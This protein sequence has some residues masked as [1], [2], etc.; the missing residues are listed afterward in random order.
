MV[1]K[2]DYK[3]T[4]LMPQTNFPMKGNLNKKEI[5]IEKHW[6]EIRL[7]EKMLSKNKNNQHFILHDGPPYAN[8][9][10]HIGHALNKIL[11]DFIL[12]FKNMQ[13][14]YAPY[15]PGWDTHGLPIEIA[16]LK[17]FS[18]E[19]LSSKNL[20]IT[21][22]RKF[23]LCFIEK[24][25][26]NFKRLGI[27]GHWD[28]YYSTLD[29]SYI[30]DQIRIFGQM[31]T[32]KLIFKNLKPVYW[33]PFLQSSLAES[34]IEYRNYKSLSIFI[35]FDII[36]S[37][38]FPN[39]QLLVWTT[40]PWTLPS[41]E[42]ICAHPNQKYHL[43][44]V[45]GKQYIIGAATLNS[46]RPKL[47]WEKMEIIN[48]FSGKKLENL[49]YIN[50]LFSK[51]RRVVLD[52]FVS[53][54]EGT[55]LVS[56][57]PGHGHDDFIIGQKYN[58]DI[59]CSIDKKGLMTEIAGIYKGI[60]FTE[61]NNLIVESLRTKNLL[62]K[63]ESITH[64][65]PHDN[66][67]QKPVIFLA[68]PQWFLNVSKI[69]DKLLK[70]VQKIKWHPEWG[71]KKMHNMMSEREHWNISRQRKWGVPIPIIYTENHEPITDINI[72][73]HIADL[74]EKN[75]KEIWHKWDAI[76]LLPPNYQN[77]KSPNQIFYKEQDIIDVWFDSGTSYSIIQRISDNFFPVNL[78][79]EGADQY[80]GWFN[81]SLITS[82]AVFNQSPYQQVITHGFVLD[83][84]G[85]KMSKSLN[86][87]V[88]PLK[89]INQTGADVL[90]LWVS[91]IDY[92]ND[93]KIDSS[94]LEQIQEKYRKI[95]NTIRFMLGNLNDFNPNQNYV[96]FNN[97]DP[98]HQTII[99]EFKY[100]LIKIIDSY[101]N[102]DFEQI[103]SLL[104]P[105][106]TTKIS[107][108]YLDFAKDI[109]Y[110]ED[111]NNLERRMI[112]SNIYDLLLDFLKILT[113]I[114]PHTTS[115][116]YNSL[117]FKNEEDIYLEK[118]PQIK[119][120]KNFINDTYSENVVIIQ[121]AYKLFLNLREIVLKKLEESRQ[122]KLIRKSL[123][124]KLILHLTPEYIKALEILKI[125]KKLNQILIVSQI[126]I[127]EK[128]TLN[129]TILMANGITCPRC[130][131][132][133]STIKKQG[134]LCQRCFSVLS[135]QIL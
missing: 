111:Q 58:L 15:I 31:I 106:I 61:A 24:Q 1:I 13:G 125:N 34:E 11:K 81:S 30:A 9:E 103:I 18:K 121:N 37:N 48:T 98:I 68:I 131:N 94:I 20:F 40:N 66:R 93:V 124:A 39:T 104:Y 12:R 14:Y 46:L 21:E 73:N 116:A 115:E 90:R 84:Y 6:K 95:R 127:K 129:I 133:K 112:Q 41:N 51:Q 25:K 29:N 42:A 16:V 53:E 22:C 79:L 128:T 36:N 3:N 4:L 60:F 64:S 69:K 45:N 44:K 96:Y 28:K 80:R 99:L 8:G 118:I 56:I 67:I 62:I 78:Y 119:E 85:Q 50:I 75:G 2:T 89:I 101:Q 5:E 70:E 43:I 100:M 27:L 102:Y 23:A 71:Q 17:K 7:Y 109:L 120:V 35:A 49:L 130:W 122:K 83:G 19:E 38:I 107:A 47:N 135:K 114:I 132:V 55:G 86:N 105:F 26:N 54:K 72:I 88:D 82:V 117:T 126:E 110:I 63:S 108:F 59:S 134:D 10:M 32:K 65:Y 87:V 123:Q 91:N 92:N 113:P 97:R 33:S 57:S 74:F 52:T 76:K 77:K